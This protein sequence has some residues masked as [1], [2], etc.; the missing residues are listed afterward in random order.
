MDTAPTAFSPLLLILGT[1]L[2][3][4]DHFA[5]VVADAAE[6]AGI[7]VERRRGAFSGRP[8]EQRTSEHKSLY[9]LWLERLFLATLPLHCRL[10]PYVTAWLLLLDLRRFS[11]PQETSVLVVSHTALRLLA[12][13][14]GHRFERTA[15]I[16]L[17]AITRRALEAI[18]PATS[19]VTVALD[20]DHRIREKR[21][22]ERVRRGTVDHF[23]RYM[24]SES[25]RSERIEQF[26][27]WI[28]QTF[29][30]AITIVNNDLSDAEL[31]AQ[32]PCRQPHPPSSRQSSIA[33][34]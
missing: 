4:K 3:G 13:A 8:A 15:Q 16:Q 17:P 26:L 34:P 19:A 5:N 9:A 31:L 7:A 14:L 32:L 12:F 28:G 25:A 20:I 1:D 24:A 21:V 33:T 23:D 6:S 11:Q 29:L 27:V 2:A 18:V 30:N 10:L 22:A